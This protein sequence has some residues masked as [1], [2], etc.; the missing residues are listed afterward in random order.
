M[1]F[2]VS[3]KEH[4]QKIS[5]KVSDFLSSS[6]K[7]RSHKQTLTQFEPA[8]PSSQDDTDQKQCLMFLSMKRWKFWVQTGQGIDE[9]TT[10]ISKISVN[11][12]YI[13][14]FIL[15]TV[16]VTHNRLG[17]YSAL[18]LLA[19]AFVLAFFILLVQL[20]FDFHWFCCKKWNVNVTSA[21][22]YC[23]PFSY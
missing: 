22:I 23:I 6:T 5:D 12:T 10:T 1:S 16:I 7:T 15:I 3:K 9:I 2:K 8:P 19:F 17:F 21:F 13:F 4:L 14:I 11:K 18:P 20:D